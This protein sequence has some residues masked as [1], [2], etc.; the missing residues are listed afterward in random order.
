MDLKAKL[1]RM[2]S[3]SRAS[4]SPVPS[5]LGARVG[6]DVGL[7][8]RTRVSAGL[9]VI[10]RVVDL[11]S[12]YGRAPL[13]RA[14][15]A[16]PS[17]LE[18]IALDATMGRAMS[19]AV[20]LDT[21]T[22]GLSGGTGTIPFLVGVLWCRDGRLHLRQWLLH[23]PSA[24][25]ELLGCLC[26][27]IEPSSTLVTYN[28]KAYDWP[29]LQTRFIL[30]RVEAPAFRP[31]LDLLHCARRIYRR[32]LG[33]VRLVQIEAQV[34]GR[35]RTGDIEGSEIPFVYWNYLRDGVAARLDPILEHN[36]NDLL[37]LVAMLG[38]MVDHFT[39]PNQAQDPM[40]QL[41]LAQLAARAR[42]AERSL[43]FSDSV[44]ARS[45]EPSVVAEAALL[46][47]KLRTARGEVASACE[48]LLSALRVIDGETLLTS[49]VHLALAKLY[50]HKLRQYDR[51]LEHGR[52]SRVAE[53]AL[54]HEKRCAR[55]ARRLRKVSGDIPDISRPAALSE[56][57]QTEA[58]RGL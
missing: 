28:G 33:G 29:L 30:N 12:S 58:E 24:E 54:A 46:S 50:E 35:I 11:S 56:A 39:T 19:E 8:T 14:F 52:R 27:V 16:P 41:S 36:Q 7:G 57:F 15:S 40:D 49:Q 6:S 47:A 25:A 31:H 53:G 20:F 5:T 22:T 21:E 42:D 55:L 51:A 18:K 2:P 9:E 48:A 26:E 4:P 44:L 17:V 34:L 37:A 3:L 23:N 1:G 13:H 10:E 45:D 43:A 38:T 32:R